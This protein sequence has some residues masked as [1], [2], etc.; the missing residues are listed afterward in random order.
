[1]NKLPEKLTQL[2]KY[3]GLSQQA[4]A[5]KAEVSVLDYMAWENGGAIPDID[6]LILLAEAFHISLDEMIRNEVPVLPEKDVHETLDIPFMKKPEEEYPTPE[7]KIEEPIQPQPDLGQTRV[8]PTVKDL[9]KTKP[10]RVVSRKLRHI[11]QREQ[12]RIGRSR[13]R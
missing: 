1:M 7:I 12:A 2:R 5:E 10:L 8:I 13:R 9:E 4:A 11:R 3:N 6:H